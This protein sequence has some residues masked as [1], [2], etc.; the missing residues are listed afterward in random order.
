M[1]NE[2]Q[3]QIAMEQG[4]TIEES[5]DGIVLVLNGDL[6]HTKNVDFFRRASYIGVTRLWME[7]EDGDN[8]V[9]TICRYRRTYGYGDAFINNILDEDECQN[10][11]QLREY[12]INYIDILDGLVE[13]DNKIDELFQAVTELID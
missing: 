5:I 11:I 7:E 9:E 12:K 4:W 8:L 1:I 10:V 3:K 13:Y 2:K 6:R